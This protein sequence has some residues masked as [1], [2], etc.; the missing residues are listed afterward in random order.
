MSQYSSMKSKYQTELDTVNKLQL[1]LMLLDKMRMENDRLKREKS[2]LLTD[3]ANAD[4]Q[5]AKF[6]ELFNKLRIDIEGNASKEKRL[7][8]IYNAIEKT[9][10][11]QII[12]QSTNELN[13]LE[14]IHTKII[15]NGYKISKRLL[16][17]FHTALLSSSI[18]PLTVLAGVSGTWKS[19]L[20][21][22]YANYGGLFFI[23]IPVEPDWDSPKSL[24]G[25]YNPIENIFDAKLLLR[26]LVQ[27]QGNSFSKTTVDD[28]E[29]K[30]PVDL[31]NFVG[32]VLLDEMNLAH[33]ELYF[34]DLLSKFEEQRN[35]DN[36]VTIPVDIGSGD[37]YSLQL[38]ENIAWVGTMNQDESTKTLS[39]KVIDRGN[40]ITFARPKKFATF[41]S[42]KP[43][44]SFEKLSAK[45]WISWKNKNNHIKEEF[46]DKY[47]YVLEQVNLKL[48]Y[49]NRSLGHRVWQSIEV[50]M[51]VHPLLSNIPQGMEKQYYNMV[52]EETY[53]K[54]FR[55]RYL[56]TWE[57]NGRM[58]CTYSKLIK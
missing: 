32:I 6:N 46:M 26:Y 5:V 24:F 54:T 34:S 35:S 36:V 17:S 18:S 16:Y 9:D 1:E 44:K 30:V 45:T 50:Y 19:L 10:K 7:E 23:S 20:P 8:S 58:Y 14:S 52:F 56:G 29:N 39:D 40:L 4:A 42:S 21:N 47:R 28:K 51:R 12:E 43:K 2:E 49:V 41:S 55:Y 11:Y 33:V 53:P 15:Q 3:L 13:W 27:F 48:Q 37:Y 57:S 25:Y 38:L 31:S 22:L